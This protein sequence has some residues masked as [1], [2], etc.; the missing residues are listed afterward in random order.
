[1][2]Y[3]YFSNVAIS[4]HQNRNRKLGYRSAIWWNYL[5]LFKDYGFDHIFFRYKTFFCFFCRNFQ[6]LFKKW[7]RE[8]TQTFN[9][10]TSFR[11]FSFYFFYQLSDWVEIDWGF[12]KLFF[13]QMLKIS[14]FILKIQKV[15]FLKEIWAKPR[16]NWLQYWNNQLCL[17][18]QL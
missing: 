7:F 11:Q 10:F 3:S 4:F 12:T 1:M 2:C 14:A 6:H 5:G 18:T 13:K 9:S 17:L 8:T 16:V 15:L